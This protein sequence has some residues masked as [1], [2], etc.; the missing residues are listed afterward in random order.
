MRVPNVDRAGRPKVVY[1][2]HDYYDS[3]AAAEA[4]LRIGSLNPFGA[5]PPPAYRLDLDLSGCTYTYHGLVPGGTGTEYTTRDGPLV[6]ATNGL[7]P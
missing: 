7:N 6:S 3:A 1:F 5:G 4:A 2:T